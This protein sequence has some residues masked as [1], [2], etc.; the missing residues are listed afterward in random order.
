[1]GYG[2]VSKPLS[3]PYCN[4]VTV[5]MKAL[6]I[7]I[8]NPLVLGVAGKLGSRSSSGFGTGAGV[9]FQRFALP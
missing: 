6:F 4:Y 5:Y 8:V 7:L 9:G 3:V 1:M 2:K